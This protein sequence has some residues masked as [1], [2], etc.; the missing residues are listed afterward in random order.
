LLDFADQAFKLSDG[1]FDVTSGVLRRLWKFDGS[2]NVP[3]RKAVKKLL[4]YI[5]WDKVQWQSSNIVLPTDMEIDLG[6]VGKEYAVDRA[7][8][9]ATEATDDPLLINFGGDLYATAAPKGKPHWL[10]G[11]DKVGGLA[12]ALVQL[13]RGGLA[14][15]GD[16]NRYLMRGGKRYSHVLNPRTGWPVGQAPSAVTV[17][18]NN[19]VD[20]GLLATFAMLAGGDAESFLQAQGCLHWVQR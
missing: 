17:A 11:V 19:C 9:L 18:A 13:E 15:S 10:V 4:P 12:S 1:A 20:A 5:G 6:G 7:A 2:D 14:T 8:L 3:S 16:A